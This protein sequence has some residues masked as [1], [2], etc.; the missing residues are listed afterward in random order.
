M[1]RAPRCI[2]SYAGSIVAIR[3]SH[4][5]SRQIGFA[6]GGRGQLGER[7]PAEPFGKVI[8]GLQAETGTVFHARTIEGTT[9]MVPSTT[10]GF[11]ALEVPRVL[12]VVDLDVPADGDRFGP[13]P[14]W[15]LPSTMSTESAST[16][17]HGDLGVRSRSPLPDGSSTRGAEE[18]VGVIEPHAPYRA[19]GDRLSRC[20][21]APK[22]IRQFAS[23]RHGRRASRRQTRRIVGAGLVTPTSRQRRS[24]RT[25][26][27]HYRPRQADAA[28]V[29]PGSGPTVLSVQ[30]AAA[31]ARDPLTAQTDAAR[32][33]REPTRRTPP[34]ARDPDVTHDD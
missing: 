25:I 15:A 23:G 5:R 16:E 8:S 17:V 27:R 9:S 12:R 31:S 34:T 32:G 19:N 3:R 29:H 4:D 7:P 13:Q 2:S 22:T 6:S 21:H 14:R 1:Y 30:P 33:S 10:I 18:D 11:V 24:A 26:G 28:A 20:R